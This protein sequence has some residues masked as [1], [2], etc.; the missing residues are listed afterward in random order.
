MEL[1]ISVPYLREPVICPFPE[2]DE[3]NPRPPI[4]FLALSHF[5]FI[6]A[7]HFIFCEIT[8]QL[9]ATLSCF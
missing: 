5:N 2:P 7:P 1:K 3:S 4:R 6:L 9:G 8:A